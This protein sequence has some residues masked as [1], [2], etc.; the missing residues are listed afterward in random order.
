MV[1]VRTPPRA[2]NAVTGA[3]LVLVVAVLAAG[4]TPA[5]PR[6][7]DDCCSIFKERRSW[8]RDARKSEKRWGVPIHVLLAIIHQESRF[9]AKARPPRTKILWILPGPR[10]SN[11]YGY[12]QALTETWQDYIDNT[13]RTGADRD[14]FS[15]AVDFVGWYG[16]RSA[17][18]NGLSKWDG[19]RLYLAYHEGDSGYRRGTYRGKTWLMRVAA[20]VRDR[21]GT[22]AVQLARCEEDLQPRWWQFWL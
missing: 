17:R 14:D 18:T 21:A 7:I 3:F 9:E 20:K 19:F 11:A 4:C 10:P 15:D 2:A 22:Y 12:T 6:N 8:Y 1:R 13:G 5:R 16:A